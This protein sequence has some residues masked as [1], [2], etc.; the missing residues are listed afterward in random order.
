[1]AVNTEAALGLM[2]T[3]LNRLAAD[4][5]LDIYYGKLIDAAQEKLTG[6]GI[7]LTDSADDL[8]RVVNYAVWMYQN[9]DQ[10][11]A[12]PDWMRKDIKERWLKQHQLNSEVDA[13]ES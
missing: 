8:L 6:M 5:S 1:M 13:D 10:S 12:M 2:K 4:T 9:R 11:G 3:R 7:S